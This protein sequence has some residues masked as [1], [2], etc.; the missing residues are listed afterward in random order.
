MGK[1]DATL[2]L[3]EVDGKYSRK[4]E[5]EEHIVMVGQP[6]EF[7]LIH[8]NPDSGTGLSIAT[9]IYNEIKDTDLAVKLN[10]VGSDGTAAMTGAHYG[11][12]RNLEELLHRRRFVQQFFKKLIQLFK[13]LIFERPS[14]GRTPNYVKIFVC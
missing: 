1:K 2:V 5:I 8:T 12:I 4:V 7:Y 9:S 13:K 6:G 14:G 3:K 10:V 11:V